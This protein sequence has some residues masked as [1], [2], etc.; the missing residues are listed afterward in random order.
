[1]YYQEFKKDYFRLLNTAMELSGTIS[2][3]IGNAKLDLDEGEAPSKYSE[4]IKRDMECYNHYLASI[5]REVNEITDYFA[6]NANVTPPV[7]TSEDAS[8]FL[9]DLNSL[10]TLEYDIY[11]RVHLVYAS[12]FCVGDEEQE[13]TPL[14]VVSYCDSILS[15]IDRIVDTLNKIKDYLMSDSYTCT[16]CSK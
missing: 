5:S 14:D 4:G 6:G 8:Q 2:S 10:Y 9:K 13:S 12:I 3:F 7:G 15:I 16:D 1:M 11:N